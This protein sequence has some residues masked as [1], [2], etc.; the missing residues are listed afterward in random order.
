MGLVIVRIAWLAEG[1]Y[2]PIQASV[3]D[4][5][6]EEDAPDTYS[7]DDEPRIPYGPQISRADKNRVRRSLRPQVAVEDPSV[8]EG[9]RF[10][11]KE[12][13]KSRY[14]LMHR[15]FGH[16]SPKTISLLHTVTD[17]PEVKIPRK[18][19]VCGTCARNKKKKRRS[20]KLA[21][22]EQRPLALVSMDLAGPFPVSY[23]G[24]RYFLE[25]VD[26]WTRRTWSIPVGS[27]DQIY[28]ELDNWVV[29]AERECEHKL[30]CTRTDNAAEFLKH[31]LGWKRRDGIKVQVTEPYT[32]HQNGPAERS[33]QT[34]E[35]N[36]RS[37][38][39]DAQLPVEFWCEAVV[40]QC[41][42]RNRQRRGPVVVEEETMPNGSVRKVER[43]LSPE[44]AW[45][46]KRP[47]GANIR[48]WGCKAYMTVSRESQ[49][50]GAR[51]DKFIPIGRDGIFMGYSEDTEKHYRFYA[52]DLHRTVI[53]T[54]VTFDETT[55]GGSIENFRLWME[56]SNGEFVEA[57][58]TPNTL[59][60]RNP[61]GRPPNVRSDIVTNALKPPK[62]AF[63]SPAFRK[64][65]GETGIDPEPSPN[66]TKIGSTSVEVVDKSDSDTAPKPDSTDVFESQLHSNT[67]STTDTPKGSTSLADN[68][69]E[70]GAQGKSAD[71]SNVTEPVVRTPPNNNDG[72]TSMSDVPVLNT[73]A[74]HPDP[75]AW[76]LPS[77]E[78]ISHVNPGRYTLRQRTKRSYAEAEPDYEDDEHMAKKQRAM[79]AMLD[80][81]DEDMDE[82]LEEVALVAA[83]TKGLDLGIKIPQTYKEAISGPQGKFWKQ[84]IQY[85][86]EQFLINETWL[87]EVPPA[88]ANLISTK[89]VFTLKFNADGTLERYKARLVARG[90]SQAYGID[91]TETFA[92]T[93][94]MATLR[95]FFAI[96]ACEDL[97]CHH[98]DIKNA[99]T[100]SELQNKLYL[101]VPEGVEKVKRGHALRL[102]K[103]LYGL[104]QAARDWNQLMRKELLGW[105][106]IQGHGDPCLYTHPDRGIT[107]LVYV[108]DIAAGAKDIG[109]LD[110]FWNKLRARF[111]AT[112]LREIKKILGVRVTRDRKQGTL[113]LDQ[114]LYLDYVLTKYGFENASSKPIAT[115]IDGYEHLRPANKK[116]KRIDASWYREV[117]GSLMY[118]MIYTR[119]DIAFVLGRLAQFMQDPAEHHASALKRLMRYLRSTIDL[120]IRFGS[121]TTPTLQAFSDADYAADKTDRKSITAFI[122]LIGGG[123]IFWGS[124]KQSSVS[125]ATTE[126][127]YIAMCTT[128]KQGQ[129]IAQVL[130]DMGYPEYIA[131]NGTTVAMK[132]DNQGAI[133]L[134]K[135][136][137]LTDRSKHIEVQY[138]YV[139]ELQERGKIDIQ[140]VPTD[141]M[142]AD[143]L[144][145]PVSRIVLDRF[146]N[147]AGM[148]RLS[149]GSSM[150]VGVRCEWE[151]EVREFESS[152]SYGAIA[153]LSGSI[154][155]VMLQP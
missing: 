148:V 127:E 144:T 85:E 25:I 36:T 154:E 44:E 100:E 145:K 139:R 30:K 34:T 42:V 126:A 65:H 66:T 117:V 81:F 60:I 124:K 133:A 105:G 20:K 111:T 37:A 76:K 119:P 121:S 155:L 128:A 69:P 93:V 92:P 12:S 22:H 70:E 73:G 98:Y 102:L 9:R 120:R 150:R 137:Q 64:D 101:Q 46:G 78:P 39:D 47:T 15:R 135:N 125:T 27:K 35:E 77:D 40:A 153:C 74:K 6:M 109:E 49:P 106:F 79:I 8:P 152:G 51:T 53:A 72:D 13:I 141:K 24:N 123:P 28:E 147:Q 84:A 23:R 116:D 17:I 61:V 1:T 56:Q 38:L 89:W 19:P 5:S 14:M 110:W 146:I 32:S 7:I 80:W 55:P 122:G 132:G 97:H 59:P 91:Y 143:S 43:Q 82:D 115:P 114:E 134:A 26:N 10:V 151:F 95:A 11:R 104:K 16:C 86:L 142:V 113:E 31:L 50:A 3:E 52:P 130:R 41:Y 107:L 149:R 83:V 96:V 99:F 33:I 18:I 112:N 58:G 90:F 140:Y 4:A 71:N 88:G 57:P 2:A 75:H 29:V 67:E 131:P 94:R 54:N 62:V 21:E 48:P 136:P 138:H 68:T 129:W 103:S 108:D 118:A 87:E 45:S 63:M